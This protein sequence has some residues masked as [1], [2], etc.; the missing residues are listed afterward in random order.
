MHKNFKH[1]ETDHQV[2]D[3]IREKNYYYRDMADIGQN[4]RELHEI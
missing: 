3:E 2:D 4:F 1:C